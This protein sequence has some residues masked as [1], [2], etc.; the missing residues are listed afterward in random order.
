M[1]PLLVIYPASLLHAALCLF[2][3]FQPEGLF[4]FIKLISPLCPLCCIF[5]VPFVFLFLLFGALI[6]QSITQSSRR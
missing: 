2:L 1:I 3:F 5:L 6:T 4:K